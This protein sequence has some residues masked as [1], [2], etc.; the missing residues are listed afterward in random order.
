MGLF[1]KKK[2]QTD[3]AQGNKNRF[4]GFVLL[5]DANWDKQKT[6]QR[7]TDPMGHLRCGRQQTTG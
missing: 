6:D 2:E 3:T 5:S 1:K 7:L 4:V